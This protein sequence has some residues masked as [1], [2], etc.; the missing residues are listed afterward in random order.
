MILQ[1]H[2]VP[3]ALALLCVLHQTGVSDLTAVGK[4]PVEEA[5]K[6]GGGGCHAGVETAAILGTGVL[7][8][9]FCQLAKGLGRLLA[10]GKFV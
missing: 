1:I 8:V 2:D 9:L 3:A 10:G 4:D 5:G 7:G 6:E